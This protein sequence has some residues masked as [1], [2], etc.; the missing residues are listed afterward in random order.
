LT[1]AALPS[2]PILPNNSYFTFLLLH[3]MISYQLLL[4]P[5]HMKMLP[6]SHHSLIIM[7]FVFFVLLAI[8]H[9][10]PAPVPSSLNCL[11]VFGFNSFQAIVPLTGQ[12]KG[13]L[14]YGGVSPSKIG[15]IAPY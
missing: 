3:A 10:G 9:T 15:L 12:E 7:M 14:F 8:H 4:I 6:S 5:F 2:I 11:V 13:V 1:I